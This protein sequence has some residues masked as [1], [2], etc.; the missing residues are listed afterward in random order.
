MAIKEE[1]I[2]QIDNFVKSVPEYNYSTE[3]PR[4]PLRWAIDY[5]KEKGFDYDMDTNG[6]QVDF[7][8]TFENKNEKYVNTGDLWY[9]K[10]YKLIKREK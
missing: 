5:F 9:E 10:Y 8:L 6:Y 2:K 3:L 1:I 7:D 4:F